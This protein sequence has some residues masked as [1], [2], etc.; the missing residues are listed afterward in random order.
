MLL[1]GISKI[2]NFVKE[3]GDARTSLGAWRQEVEEAQWSSPDDVQARYVS[4]EVA[5]D[6]VVFSIKNMCK[7]SV[8]AKFKHGILLIESVWPL[9]VAKQIR[10]LAKG[11]VIGSKA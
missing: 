9:S 7:I 4:A 2:E 10:K 5:Q 11:V 1:L 3:H 6:R 8:K